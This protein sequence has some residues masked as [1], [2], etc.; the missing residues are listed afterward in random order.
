M[1]GYNHHGVANLNGVISAWKGDF[2]ST[3]DEGNHQRVLQLQI[4]QR[5]IGCTRLRINTEFKCLNTVVIHVI[6]CFDIRTNGGTLG[7]SIG[8]DCLGCNEAWINDGSQV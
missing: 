2:S 7:T 3:I 5:D 8:N 4:L 6:Q 1:G